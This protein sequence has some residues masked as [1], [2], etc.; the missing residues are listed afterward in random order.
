M[1]YSE[2]AERRVGLKSVCA[3]CGALLYVED[4]PGVGTEAVSHGMCATC[5][6]WFLSRSPPKSVEEFVD[7]LAVPVLVIG[8]DDMV[9]FGNR[10]A[11]RMLNRDLSTV[12]GKRG[13][14]VIECVHA[15]EPGGCG[16]TVHCKGC[17]IRRTIMDTFASGEPHDSVEAYN[18]VETSQGI[19]KVR[20]LLST[21]KVAGVVLLRIEE[22]PTTGESA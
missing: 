19:R 6:D 7:S 1:C 8:A 15:R 2:G 5:S 3:W 17:A 9:A 21:R 10:T 4:V 13:G 22:A 18:Q 12:V 14:D 20:Y 11:C 16:Q